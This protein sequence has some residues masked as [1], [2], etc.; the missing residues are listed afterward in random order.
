MAVPMAYGDSQ[1]YF[2]ITDADVARAR[3]ELQLRM[4]SQYQKQLAR[5]ESQA[6]IS[7][8]NAYASQMASGA[9]N[10]ALLNPYQNAYANALNVTPPKQA[11]SLDKV[12]A[13]CGFGGAESR[14][15]SRRRRKLA[16]L[17]SIPV[18]GG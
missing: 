17:A 16:V 11:K 18:T 12:I 9:A 5:A 4:S 10:V 3:A 14:P 2:R 15:R 7:Q 6:A 13:D 1:A 8:Y